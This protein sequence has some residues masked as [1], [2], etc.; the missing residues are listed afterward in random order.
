MLFAVVE[1]LVSIVMVTETVA[2]ACL[3]VGIL[4]IRRHASV[5]PVQHVVDSVYA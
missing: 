4:D 5:R 2:R 3:T 1:L